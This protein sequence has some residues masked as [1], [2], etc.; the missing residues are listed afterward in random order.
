MKPIVD[1][2]DR[3]KSAD[4]VVGIPSLNEADSIGVPTDAAGV[5][6]QEFFPQHR[7]VIINVDNHSE[8]GTKEAF[9]NTPTRCPKVYISTPEG[10]RGKGNNFRNLFCAAVELGARAVVVVDADLTSITPSW[11]RYL[12]EPVLGRFDYVS[13]I[14][15]RHKYDGTITNHIAYPMLRS[16]FGLRV[17]QPIG[18]DFGFSGKMARAWLSERLWNDNVARFGIDIWMTTTAIAR[19]QFSVCQ[20]FL[21]SPKGHKPKD[22]AGDLTPMFTQVVATLFDLTKEF[23]YFWKEISESRPSSVF[24]FGLGVSSKVDPIEI[25][26][27]NLFRQFEAGS[28]KYPEIWQQTMSPPVRNEVQE[29]QIFDSADRF[30]MTTS[31]WA[32]ILFD[33]A[34]ANRNA[35]IPQDQLLEA[36]VPFYH[37]RLLA[38]VNRTLEMDTHNA[39]EYLENIS[40]TFQKEKHYLIQRWDSTANSKEERMFS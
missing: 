11:I 10:V 20:A 29:L 3:V 8:D 24:G 40:R 4:I 31:L 17:R 2:P 6:L 9:L 16:L 27:E 30:S 35:E 26:T 37:A 1:N 36:L 15:V 5:G 38:Y 7:S 14:Y 33:F 23:E 28:R 12:A 22:P 18:G 34:V 21:G 25:D 32:R 39:E 19:M 13:P